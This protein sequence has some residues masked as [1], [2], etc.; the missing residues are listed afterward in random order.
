MRRA[1]GAAPRPL[2]RRTPGSRSD[3]SSTTRPA[4]TRSA[5]RSGQS[6]SPASSPAQTATAAP[7]HSLTTGIGLI[8]WARSATATPISS[9]AIQLIEP[10][11]AARRTAT[12]MASP[13]LR[14]RCET[15]EAEMSSAAASSAWV[16]PS[17]MPRS[18]RSDRS[19]TEPIIWSRQTRAAFTGAGVGALGV[20]R[21]TVGRAQQPGARVLRVGLDRLDGR[22][23][24]P[25]AR[26]VLDARL[27]RPARPPLPSR[28]RAG[29][30]RGPGAG[31]A[32][33]TR[34]PPRPPSRSSPG[35]R[36]PP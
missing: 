29:A 5:S 10:P 9:T 17:R 34:A 26:T 21:Q 1:R 18:S 32:T 4:I 31:A 13:S 3:P 11:S 16:V 12:I 36:R 19:D 24:H 30:G 35:T 15:A 20:L 6:V 28:R 14:T 25:P 22:P 33:A 23:C 7:V 2:A 8:E 27:G